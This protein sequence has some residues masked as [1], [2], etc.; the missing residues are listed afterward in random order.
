MRKLFASLC[1]CMMILML[2]VMAL[3]MT[4]TEWNQQCLLKTSA[5]V[6]L[7]KTE[8]SGGSTD[9][10]TGTDIPMY[11]S[12]S[13]PAGTY[14]KS[15]TYDSQLNMR[16]IGYYSNGSEARAFVRTNSIVSAV[17][18]VEID[19]GDTYPVPEA[20]KGDLQALFRYLAK[21]M[22]GYTFS[23]IPGSSKIHKEK[24]SGSSSD[25]STNNGS[26]GNRKMT[27]WERLQE[28]A[29]IA[30]EALKVDPTLY[31][32]ALIYAPRTGQATLRQKA[33]GNGKMVDKLLDGTVVWILEEGDRFSRVLVGVDGQT[34]YIINSALEMLDPEELPYGAGVLT[35][36]GDA[37]VRRN[38]DMRSDSQG[39]GRK[40][41][42]WRVGTQVII[43]SFSEDEKW[44]EV[45][46]EGVRL[47]VQA[48]YLTITEVYDY[49]TPEEALE[50]ES[51]DDW[52]DDYGYDEDDYYSYDDYDDEG[53]YYDYD[54]YWDDDE[55]SMN[56]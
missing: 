53:G 2:P 32:K 26:S 38:I 18:H 6:T 40:V 47:H 13:L 46:Y 50:E 43:W 17:W 29:R 56:G 31:P 33:A 55:A 14:I 51:D 10:A 42:S 30:A 45:E 8:A 7:Y 11:V 25:S 9:V 37:S 52:G 28:S 54:D 24:I 22:P 5:S 41:T 21:E 39:K 19:D 4:E 36:K 23:S 1:V 34:G 48:D 49:S 16:E 27:E 15:Y 12:G 20:L 35:Y 44:Y 3:A